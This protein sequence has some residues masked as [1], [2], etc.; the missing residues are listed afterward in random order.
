MPIGRPDASEYPE[1][2]ARYIDLVPEDDVCGALVQQL[3]HT[4]ALLGRMPA[5]KLDFR[6]APDKWTT[7]EVVGHILDT[8]RVFGFR[9]L[10]FARGDTVTF[11]RADEKLYVGNAAF[12][13][14]PLQEWLDEFSL[15]RRS[16][17]TLVRH[18]PEDAWR[19]IGTL[20]IGTVSVRA[21]AYLM[22]GHERHHLRI[23]QDR[24]L[25]A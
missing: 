13:R 20:A 1:R 10:T 2:Y 4:V 9:L 5:S 15:V 8:E 11:P 7:R 19:R 16:N 23:I 14:Y 12:G 24:Y 22:V 6:Y 18:L 17:A 25:A 3:E 21:M